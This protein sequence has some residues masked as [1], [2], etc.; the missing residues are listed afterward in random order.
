VAVRDRDIYAFSIDYQLNIL[1]NRA[2]KL[3]MLML[4]S[5]PGAAQNVTIFDTFLPGNTYVCCYGEY[6]A[7]SAVANVVSLAYGSQAAAPFTPTGNFTLTQI[8]IPISIAASGPYSTAINLSLNQDSDGVPGA[9]LETWAGI[10]PLPTGHGTSSL[11]TTIYPAFTVPLLAGKQY[12]IVA[13][14]AASNTLELWLLNAGDGTGP[15]GRMALNQGL[16]W[17]VQVLPS[18]NLAFDVRG[19]P[20]SE[21]FTN[22][23]R[24]PQIVDGAGWKTRFTITNTDEV[25]VTFKFQFWGEGG[26]ALPFPI[27]NGT[28]GVLSGTLS[29]GGS[30]FAESPG[31]AAIL[32][33]GWAEIASSG[34]IGVSAIYQF[35]ADGS[36]DSL[37]T[38]IAALSTNSAAMAFDNTEGNATAIAVANT[39]ST[40]PL[41]V[42]MLFVTDSGVQSTIS[43]SLPPRTRQ[44]FVAATMNSAI[45]GAHGLIKF[46]A[47]S[48]DMA[49]MGLQFTPSGQFTSAGSFNGFH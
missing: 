48:S 1:C 31:T 9:A 23:V 18:G 41:T 43:L 24:V 37:G 33:Q 20:T 15:R 7:G 8:D 42:S 22:A 44:A 16:G 29:P 4:L 40:Q 27:A 28:S 32:R 25:P 47:P 39:N 17:I 46:S 36:R 45:A 5:L 30:F 10:I 49:V 13:S 14:P 26:A 34:Q 35:S 21:Y 11:A 6:I 38:E 19:T 2:W 12:W 3:A